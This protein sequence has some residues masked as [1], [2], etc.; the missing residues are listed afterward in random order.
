MINIL[1]KIFLSGIIIQTLST[2]L[3]F[4]QVKADTSYSSQ[5][6]TMIITYKNNRN[7]IL[8]EEYYFK[9]KFI[10]YKSWFYKKKYLGYNLVLGDN[11]INCK[12]IKRKFSLDNTIIAEATTVN[13]VLNGPLKDY[14]NNG[15][16][17]SE[18]NFRNGKLDSITS[19]Y[20]DNGQL[21]TK[22]LFKKNKYM[23]VLSNYN[24]NGKIVPKGDLKDGYGIRYV[25]DDNGNLMYYEHFSRG[26]YMRKSK[27][28]F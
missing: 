15:K 16:L 4:S 27:K 17:K 3:L 1:T 12:I 25:Y 24:R 26:Y 19:I 6:D 13:G 22:I 18:S 5:K 8:S 2:Q 23:E 28:I 21:W 14:Y 10:Y 7:Q 9:N 20:F 11:P